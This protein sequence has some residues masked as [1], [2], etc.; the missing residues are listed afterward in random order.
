MERVLIQGFVMGFFL[1]LGWLW[2]RNKSPLLNRDLWINLCTGGSIFLLLAPLMRYLQI[3]LHGF[4]SLISL[5]ELPISLQF[6][7]AF[8]ILDF[9]RYWLHFAHHRVPFLWSFHRV[10]H[11]SEHLDATSGLRMHAVDFIQLGLLPILL[12]VI[13]FDTRSFAEW[14]IPSVMLVGVFF[15]AFQHANIS[16]DIQKP[17]QK[18]WHLL[19]NNPH[20]HVW[21]HT[22]DGMEIDGN[23]GNSLLIWDRLFGTDVTR[24][25]T[26]LELGITTEQ[27]L[28]NDPLSLQM[29]RSRT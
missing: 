11:S 24:E 21:H 1:L 19:L 7:F 22:R 4:S 25:N 14:I 17:I 18:I 10:H 13:L 5:P 6:L 27:A 16:F 23:Y 2:P 15:D 29:L 26:P 8:L 12:F 28:Q 20:F 3:S 9:C